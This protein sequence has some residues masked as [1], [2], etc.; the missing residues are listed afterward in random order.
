M[1]PAIVYILILNI[2]SVDLELVLNV[3]SD[4]RIGLSIWTYKQQY[5]IPKIKFS[6]SA[7]ESARIAME[8]KDV[9]RHLHIP[10]TVALMHEVL[11]LR[12]QRET[13]AVEFRG[14]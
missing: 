3:Y 2:T 8:S 13:V 6:C 7:H 12:N 4:F 5:F 10:Y 1:F 14:A 11:D 9:A